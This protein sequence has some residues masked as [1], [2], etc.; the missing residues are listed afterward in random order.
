ME[1]FNSNDFNNKFNQFNTELPG[2]MYIFEITKFC[3]YSTFIYM[4]KYETILDLYTRVSHHFC[5]KDIKGLYID[6]HLYKYV[7]D[8]K[9][10]QLNNN[11]NNACCCS[12]KKDWYI[13]IPISSITTIKEFVFANTAMEPRNLEPIYPLPSPVVYRIYLDDAH[14]HVC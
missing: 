12:K 11:S 10:N 2:R 6:N 13:P 3:G 1:D 4:Y 14:C 7:D 5:C 9:K 8:A